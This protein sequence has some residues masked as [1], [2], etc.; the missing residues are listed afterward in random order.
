MEPGCKPKDVME[1]SINCPDAV[2]CKYTS[3]CTSKEE[4]KDFENVNI[5]WANV[6]IIIYTL[7][8]SAGGNRSKSFFPDISISLI[9]RGSL[10]FKDLFHQTC[11]NQG[12]PTSAPC[13]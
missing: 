3:E 13:A 11:S 7:V 2:I 12:P 8:A 10:S 5:V 4:H 1:G 9:L 6:D